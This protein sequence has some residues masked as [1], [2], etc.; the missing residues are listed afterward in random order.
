[1]TWFGAATDLIELVVW[2]VVVLT[3]AL[4]FRSRLGELV[5]RVRRLSGGGL[6]IELDMLAETS[7]ESHVV[8]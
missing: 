8:V 7:V 1:M 2:P 6:D 3:L 5:G 4:L